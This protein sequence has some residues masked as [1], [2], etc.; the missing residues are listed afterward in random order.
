[1]LIVVGGA[2]LIP[3]SDGLVSILEVAVEIDIYPGP[4]TISIVWP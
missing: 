4:R 1:M 3:W 2:V